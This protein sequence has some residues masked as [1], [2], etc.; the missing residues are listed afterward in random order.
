MVGFFAGVLTVFQLLPVASSAQN[1]DNWP[2]VSYLR[3][4]YRSVSVV[5]RVQVRKAEIVNR[6]GG[7]EDWHLT[8]DVIESFKGRFRKGS[9]IDFYHGAEKGIRQEVFLGDKIVFLFRNFVEKENR[10]V[11]AV[12]ENSTLSYTPDRAQKL[13]VIQR[14]AR[15]RTKPRTRRAG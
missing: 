9:T 14:A 1:D 12:L 15:P 8:G 13:R 7:Y 4:D 3:S 6:I 11:L 10:W 2:S 5:A